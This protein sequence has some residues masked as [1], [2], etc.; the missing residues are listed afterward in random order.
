MRVGEKYEAELAR[1]IKRETA[2]QI[3]RLVLP[4]A[5]VTQTCAE[6]NFSYWMAIRKGLLATIEPSRIEG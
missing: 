4:H 6:P 2:R 1:W 5:L 3:A